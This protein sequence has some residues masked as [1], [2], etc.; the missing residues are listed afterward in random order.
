MPGR[1]LTGTGDR[2]SF[3]LYKLC[4]LWGGASETG[5]STRVPWHACSGAGSDPGG[6]GREVRVRISRSPR[7]MLAPWW[8]TPGQPGSGTGAGDPDSR[9]PAPR[10]RNQGPRPLQ[11]L[12]PQPGDPPSW[13]V[14][15]SLGNGSGHRTPLLK[16]RCSLMN[17]DL[18]P[19]SGRDPQQHLHGPRGEPEGRTGL[20]ARLQHG[21]RFGTG[22][23][24][25]GAVAGRC[26]SLQV[27]S[28]QLRV[29]SAMKTSVRLT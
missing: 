13:R 4:V 1:L 15:L 6:L 27:T 18:K 3:C 28:A 9:V 2:A 24:S 21:Q 22:C 29:I 12:G 7:V 20:R 16:G 11:S 5:P 23:R 14:S 8:T 19:S 26:V 10:G 25:E 17:L